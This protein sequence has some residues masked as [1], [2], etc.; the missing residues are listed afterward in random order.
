VTDPE[1]ATPAAAH[2]PGE[3]FA[4]GREADVYA[5][6]DHRVLRRYRSG[7]DASGEAEVMA[8]VGRLGYPVPEVF[9]V[10]GSDLVMARLTGPTMSTALIG[11]RLPLDEGAA[12]LADLLRR[13]HELPPW[14]DA[15]AGASVVHLDLHPENVI[16]TGDGP[17]V[18]DWRNARAA[19]ADLDTAL[20]ALIMA[21]IVVGSIPHELV[22]E[23]GAF[24]DAFL[25]RAPGDP[26]RLLDDALAMRFGNP[27]MSRDELGLLSAAGAR[28]REGRK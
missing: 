6:D 17:V 18:I 25:A 4:A 2:P 11:H 12:M 9:D 16:L 3:P 20:T 23:A 19:P 24:L 8:Y 1:A 5:L 15:P 14:A 28:V 27:T 10:H 26:I 21:Q 13:L 7:A 22:T